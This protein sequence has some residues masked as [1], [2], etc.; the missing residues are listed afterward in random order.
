MRETV[1]E[2]LQDVAFAVAPGLLA[3]QQQGPERAAR[4]QHQ[5]H[6]QP[7]RRQPF[8]PFLAE[9]ARKVMGAGRLRPVRRLPVESAER[10]VEP[11][12]EGRIA[13]DHRAARDRHHLAAALAVAPPQHRL[14]IGHQVVG[15][16]DDDE[17]ELLL[18]LGLAR[19]A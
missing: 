12:R 19:P 8:G 15:L 4:A 9:R 17:G 2:L 5:R 7:M 3:R 6:P 16:V 11:E 18:G 10:P 14:A 13:L 1:G